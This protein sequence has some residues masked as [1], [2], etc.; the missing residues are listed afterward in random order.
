MI[1]SAFLYL[2]YGAVYVIL[3]PL[4]LLDDVTLNSSIATNIA[5]YN[6]YLGTADQFFPAYTLVVIFAIIIGIE[7]AIFTYKGIMWLV[8]KVPG[9]S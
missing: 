1:G 2:L 8:R 9:I 3:S 5:T 7:F 4:R 6:G